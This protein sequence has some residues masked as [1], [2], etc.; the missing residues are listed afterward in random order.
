MSQV[1]IEISLDRPVVIGYCDVRP[2]VEWSYRTGTDPIPTGTAIRKGPLDGPVWRSGDF[3][4]A[5]L[6]EMIPPYV[7]SDPEPVG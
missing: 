6:V 4:F 2:L 1:T 3:I 7:G 5:L